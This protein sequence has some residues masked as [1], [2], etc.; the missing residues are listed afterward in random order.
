MKETCV[1]LKCLEVVS[2]MEKCKV[3]IVSRV[4]WSS[5]DHVKSY[6]CALGTRPFQKVR[7]TTCVVVEVILG[8]PLPL[9]EAE[10]T[11]VW[12]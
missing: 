9:K 3:C 8:Q 5:Y 7:Y 1:N 10:G 2:G 11:A 6:D 12:V 4:D